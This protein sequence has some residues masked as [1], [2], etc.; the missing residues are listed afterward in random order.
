MNNRYAKVEDR[1]DLIKDEHTGSFI[2]TSQSSL[3]KAR[4]A[5]SRARRNIAEKKALED[6]VSYLEDKL[7]QLLLTL[8]KE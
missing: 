5:Q 2:N 1:E 8:G 4:I 3:I 6:K 7:N